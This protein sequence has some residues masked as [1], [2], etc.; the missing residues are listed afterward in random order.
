MPS[1]RKNQKCK[2]SSYT[3]GKR[4]LSSFVYGMLRS[5]FSRGKA[6]NSQNGG[7]EGKKG[8]PG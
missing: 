7:V 3:G 2:D 1:Q 5:L 6:R 8:Y 4:G